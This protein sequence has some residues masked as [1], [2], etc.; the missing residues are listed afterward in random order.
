ME[1]GSLV[2]YGTRTS[3]LVG[4]VATGVALLIGGAVGLAAGTLGGLID[5]GLMRFTELVD[6]IPALLL[7][8]FLVTLWGP[9]LSQIALAI[10][11]SGW[12]SVARVLRARDRKS[13]V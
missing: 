2:V 6:A 7:A 4:L 1:P 3:L 8:L 11:F 13:V 9:G 10:G 12:S 5:E